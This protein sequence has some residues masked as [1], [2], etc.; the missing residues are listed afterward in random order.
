[1]QPDFKVYNW[2]DI[3]PALLDRKID[4]I[5]A[6]MVI[7]PQRALKINFSQP[8]ASSG[9]GLATNIELTKDF[10]GL[11][12]LNKTG[13]KLAAI[14]GTVSEDLARR[15]FPE[16][17]LL[18]FQK[19]EEAIRAVINSQVHGYVENNPLPTFIALE[20]PEKVDEPLSKPLLTT[21]AGF[22]VNKGDPD[23]LNFLNAWIVAREADSWLESAHD[24]WFNSLRW[25]KD[26]AK[27]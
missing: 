19:S 5:I 6:G 17:T 16:A 13:V 10:N 22:A 21:R 9:I 2:A 8:Y 24:Y 12:D 4:I 1:M 3:L 7:T 25:R 23:F 14:T 26:A 20:N 18:D 27:D 11:G 15:I